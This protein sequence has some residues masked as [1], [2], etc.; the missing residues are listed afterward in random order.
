MDL[1]LRRRLTDEVRNLGATHGLVRDVV[2]NDD[3]TGTVS[4]NPAKV[5][6]DPAGR[7][8]AGDTTAVT[9]EELVRAYLLTRLATNYGYDADPAILE[10]ERSYRSVGRPGKGGRVDILVRRRST[11]TNADLV[12]QLQHFSLSSA[13]H[14]AILTTILSTSTVSSSA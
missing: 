2:L 12:D 11:A 10:L 5:W 8:T 3:G 7:F 9:D 1:E 6:L 13:K 14:Q 4:Y